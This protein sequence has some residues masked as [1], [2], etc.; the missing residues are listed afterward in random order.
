MAP[1]ALAMLANWPGPIPASNQFSFSPSEFLM[2]TGL[3]ADDPWPTCTAA[4]G[5]QAIPSISPISRPA[6]AMALRHAST[7]QLKG[8]TSGL[9]YILD[10]PAP[11][12]QIRRASFRER[13]CQEGEIRVVA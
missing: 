9:R 6:S 7:A 1:I 11:E 5:Q 12:I 10:M 2:S 3:A 8:S 4:C 13:G